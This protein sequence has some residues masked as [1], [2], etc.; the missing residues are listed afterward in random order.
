MTPSTLPLTP[1]SSPTV[2]G[3]RG[4]KRILF[5]CTH[6]AC[7]SPMAEGIVN[8]LLGDRFEAFSAGTEPA[9][10]H[11]LAVR[12][13]SEIGIDIS[14]HVSK[15][16]SAFDGQT[17]DSVITLCGDPRESCPFVPGAARRIHIGFPDPSTATGTPEEILARF[18][19]VR[20][21]IKSTL[22]TW[23]ASGKLTTSA[24]GSSDE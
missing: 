18:R 1:D 14:G 7:R 4:K 3:N 6:N 20:D 5:V 10:V 11:P 24:G 16:L 22:L 23:A 9:R 2:D 12:V 21:E 8:H 17:F 19:E 15:H 13:M